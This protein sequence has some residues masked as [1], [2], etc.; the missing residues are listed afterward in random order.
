MPVK[1]CSKDGKPGFK[2][3]DSGFCYTYDE[4]NEQSRTEAKRKAN[5]Q[6]RAARASGWT[7]KSNSDIQNLKEKTMQIQL[8]YDNADEIK[9]QHDSMSVW[10]RNMADS[11]AKAADWHTTQSDVLSKAMNNVPLDPEKVSTTAVGAKG[12]TTGQPPSQT[13]SANQVPLDPV[14]KAEFIQILKDHSALF[15]DLGVSIEK[16]A[17]SIIGE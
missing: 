13:P 12:G 14:K 7:E 8:P 16:L 3:G 5:E 9:K 1:S 11:H 17:D 2:F 4:N 6:E 10:H 15:G